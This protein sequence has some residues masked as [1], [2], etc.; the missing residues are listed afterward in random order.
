MK[1]K[2]K[3]IKPDVSAIKFDCGVIPPGFCEHE[4]FLPLLNEKIHEIALSNSVQ[5]E[6]N[7]LYSEFCGVVRNEMLQKLSNRRIN[8]KF[9]LDNKRRRNRRPWWNETLAAKWNE[10]CLAERDWLKSKGRNRN[11]LKDI[12]VRVR[13]V[14]DREVQRTK[15][16][17][18]AQLQKEMVNSVDENP[19]EFWKTIGRTG[20]ADNRNQ[21]IPFEVNTDDGS[22]S[23]D[24]KLILGKWKQDFEQMYNLQATCNN[25][26]DL[27]MFDNFNHDY[28]YSADA[29]DFCCPITLGEVHKAVFRL[30]S[31]N[32]SGVDEIPGEVLKNTKVVAFLHSLFNICFETGKIPETWSRGIINPISKASTSDSRDPLSYRGITLAPVT[33][34]VYCSIL[35]ERLISWNDQQNIIVDE[36]NGFRKKRSTLDHLTSLTSVIETRKKVRKSTYCAFIDFKKAYDTVNRDILWHKLQNIGIKDKL[37]IAIKALYEKVLCT[38]R[39]NGFNTDWFAVKCGL[40]QGCPLSPVLFSFFI[41]DLAL[42]IKSTNVGVVCGEDIVSILLFADDI[43]LLAEN[44]KDLQFLLDTLHHWCELNRM[45]INGTKSNIVHF[46]TPSIPRTRSIFTVGECNLEVVESYKYLG[47]LLNEYLDFSVTAKSCS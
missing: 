23:M 11:E 33:Y 6:V 10:V 25:E 17:Y 15:R 1:I 29:S 44:P 37:F 28:A 30:K 39:I 7:T 8:L 3:V 34:K 41:N 38:V 12:F 47:F 18:W 20:L 40:K 32:A 9:G 35:N 14:F 16:Q 13:K 46:R 4:S 2:L 43:V 26:I 31:N 45:V 22:I 27:Q 42:K 36:Q 19:R 21:K 24:P 5:E